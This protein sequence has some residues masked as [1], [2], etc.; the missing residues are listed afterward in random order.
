MVVGSVTLRNASDA[1]VPRL[2]RFLPRA[3]NRLRMWIVTSPKSMSTGQGFSHLWH[4]VQSSATSFN[5]SKWRIEM[6]RRVCSSYRNASMMRPA[7]RI[8]L[9]GEY[10]RLA[11]GTCVLH[12]GLHLPQRRQCLISSLSAPSSLASKISASCSTRR[13][14]GVYAPSR[15][16][17]ASRLPR[18][19]GAPGGAGQQLAVVEAAVGVD[20]VLVARERLELGRVEIVQFG[21][22]D[23]V[24]A[25]D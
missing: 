19:K 24:L 12:T 1:R 17:P 15:V 5:S 8:L 23:A 22:A 11:R 20:V 2:R 10:S 16:A 25:R 9:R 3:R 18:L 6:P 4:T 14:D 21:N 13:S 7:A